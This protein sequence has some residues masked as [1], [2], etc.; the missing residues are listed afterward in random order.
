MRLSG[1]LGTLTW[2]GRCAVR[3]GK[4]SPKGLEM[5]FEGGLVEDR[6]TRTPSV[7]PP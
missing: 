5:G 2:L 1:E 7:G 3:K 6:G 4:L